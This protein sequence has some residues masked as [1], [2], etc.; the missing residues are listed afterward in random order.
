MKKKVLWIEDAGDTDLS[1]L[2][3]Y[4]SSIGKYDLTIAIDVA[5]GLKCLKA[6]T[7]DVVVVDIRVLP[8]DSKSWQDL[9][10]DLGGVP[11]EAK[12]GRHL[13]YSIC[14]H[15]EARIHL[16]PERPDWISAD[17]IAVF[18]VENNL[19]ADMS[20]LGIGTYF[21]KTASHADGEKMLVKVVESVLSR[22]R[23]D[24]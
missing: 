19:Q 2:G 4:L 20:A 6:T 5:D 1:E 11:S 24:N 23:L 14:G 9:Y 12:L 17:G 18:T 3:G 16:G 8:G 10:Y 7:F 15:P 13:L 21:I 22:K